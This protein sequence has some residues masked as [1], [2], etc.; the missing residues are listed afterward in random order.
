MSEANSS[1]VGGLLSLGRERGPT[2]DPSPPLASRAGGRGEECRFALPAVARRA[3]AR[4]N[5]NYFFFKN[6]SYRAL[7]SAFIG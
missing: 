6:A 3:K 2:P 7:V 4:R 5:D 1:R